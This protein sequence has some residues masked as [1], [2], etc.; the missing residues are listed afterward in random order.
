[1]R[2]LSSLL[3]LAFTLAGCG[4]PELS[5][6]QAPETAQVEAPAAASADALLLATRNYVRSTAKPVLT[7]DKVLEAVTAKDPNFV[8]FDVRDNAEHFAA[9]H[10]EGSTYVPFGEWADPATLAKLPPISEGKSIVLTCYSGH[11]GSALA[12]YLRQLGYKAY[13]LK[14]GMFGWTSDETAI[15]KTP[16]CKLPLH[17]DFPV[18]TEPTLGQGGHA[19]PAFSDTGTA[20]EIIRA[21]GSRAIAG[22]GK[23]VVSAVALHDSMVAGQPLGLVV[24][25]READLYGKGHIE[26]AINI[27]IENIA[28]PESLALLPADQRLILVCKSGHQASQATLLLRELGYDAVALM[29]GMMT[30]QMTSSKLECT[31]ANPV[32]TD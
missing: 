13:A 11:K 26:G 2:I 29:G 6:Q 15:G 20:E 32:V 24:D 30:W 10:I 17:E 27:P 7:A 14:F 31:A 1:M 19:A 18:V 8:V 28:E 5:T 22:M 12:L 4:E 3:F 9:G 25:V 21:A 23:P 16:Y